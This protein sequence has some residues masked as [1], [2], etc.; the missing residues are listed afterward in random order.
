MAQLTLAGLGLQTG[1][2]TL[3]GVHVCPVCLHLDPHADGQQ[4]AR[5]CCSVVHSRLSGA[6]WGPAVPVNAS[7]WNWKGVTPALVLLAKASHIAKPYND[8]VEREQVCIF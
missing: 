4:L 5:A 8:E 6:P 2:Q 7:H 1:L 3:G